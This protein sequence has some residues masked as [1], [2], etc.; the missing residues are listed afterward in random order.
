M[1]RSMMP[2]VQFASDQYPEGSPS[3]NGVVHPSETV[4]ILD[5][6]PPKN[7]SGVPS[8]SMGSAPPVPARARYSVPSAPQVNPLGLVRPFAT[9]SMAE[10]PVGV[11]TGL[12]LWL[13]TATGR[14]NS[15]ASRTTIEKPSN[16][17]RCMAHSM[18]LRIDHQCQRAPGEAARPPI[19][20]VPT[21][22][23]Y[24]PAI[25][26]V[27]RQ[28]TVNVRLTIVLERATP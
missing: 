18:V 28:E 4:T 5:V 19:L 1:A 3:S 9:T 21:R 25:L 15:D 22:R 23:P 11:A 7:G 17:L 12:A 16:V 14:V 6:C 13:A 2:H 8:S 10:F 27:P 26:C 24:S 20:T